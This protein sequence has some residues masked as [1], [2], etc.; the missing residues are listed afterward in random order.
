MAETRENLEALK[1]NPGVGKGQVWWMQ[2]ELAEAEKY[3][4]RR[5]KK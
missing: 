5:G 4:A 1:N 2:N 3:M